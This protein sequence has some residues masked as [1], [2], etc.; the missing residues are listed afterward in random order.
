[1]V[2]IFQ[3]MEFGGDHGFCIGGT[4]CPNVIYFW[5]QKL[6]IIS[7]FISIPYTLYDH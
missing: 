4:L 7:S 5:A 2:G 1:M 6:V 3:A